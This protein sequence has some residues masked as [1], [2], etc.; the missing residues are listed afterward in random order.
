MNEK[1]RQ[2]IDFGHHLVSLKL[3]K[4]IHL[5]K[6]LDIRRKEKKP[7]GAL[8]RELKYLELSQVLSILEAQINSNNT[9]RFG[10]IAVEKKYLT[11]DQLDE[12]LIKQEETM[13]PIK[14]IFQRFEELPYEEIN[15]QYKIFLE[16][17]DK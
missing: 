12:L 11:K 7:I 8:A 16:K 4:K 1:D 13:P 17:V 15:N 5:M 3:I 2:E 14:D 6:A 10:D 9:E